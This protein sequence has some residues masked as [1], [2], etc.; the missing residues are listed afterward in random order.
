M[1]EEI[2]NLKFDDE[3][4][5]IESALLEAAN[6]ETVKI[7]KIYNKYLNY[8]T[9]INV[10]DLLNVQNIDNALK[11]IPGALDKQL[12]KIQ[13]DT[14]KATKY[15]DFVNRTKEKDGGYTER[16]KKY[17][18]KKIVTIRKYRIPIELLRLTNCKVI[19]YPRYFRIVPNK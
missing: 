7:A 19:Q 12:K 11:K 16:L 15:D 3:G 6:E 17:R 13:D 8:K 4:N 5:I 10:T 18:G 1:D 2:N 14:A 9:F